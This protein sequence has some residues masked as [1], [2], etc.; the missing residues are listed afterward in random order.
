VSQQGTAPLEGPAAHRRVRV[1]HD[2]DDHAHNLSRWSQ[3]Y[4]QFSAGRFEGA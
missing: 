1:A 4:N 2:A 3:S